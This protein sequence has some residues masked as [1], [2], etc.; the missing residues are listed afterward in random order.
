LLPVF[1]V[2]M[3]FILTANEETLAQ[4]RRGQKSLGLLGQ[5]VEDFRSVGW[6]VWQVVAIAKNPKHGHKRFFAS[7]LAFKTI[8]AL[9]PALAILMAVLA[10]DAFSFRRDQILDQIVDV[11]YPVQTQT[12]NSFLDPDEPQNLQ[13][14]NQI[15]KQ[16]IRIS[17]KKFAAYSRRAGFLG[18]IGFMIVVFLLMRDIE[19]AF[20]FLWGIESPRRII[21]Q[22][23]RHAVFFIGLPIAA[24]ILLTLKG[25]FLN[26]GLVHPLDH[27]WFYSTFL[28]FLT[29]AAA[30]AFMYCLVPNTKVEMRSAILAGLLISF[31]L[32][33]ARWLMNW[34]TLKIFE[35]N[36]VYGALWMI[37]VI[38]L[39]FYL[40]WSVV[41]FGAELTYFIQKHRNRHSV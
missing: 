38:L 40:S 33:I 41:L 9:V 32:A 10:N 29:V 37:P 19:H 13:Q 17:M 36:H 16:E 20:N 3:D 39:W 22:M 28:P 2:K 21:F 35:R 15:G 8:L 31:L 26:S 30:C 5:F 11:I 18:F 24:I 12:D 7:S 4:I 6:A 27:E 34:Y 1:A 23:I 14:L 25:W